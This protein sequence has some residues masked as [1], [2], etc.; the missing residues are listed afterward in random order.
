MT[1]TCRAIH[2]AWN[3]GS[4]VLPPT[5]RAIHAAWNVGIEEVDP[6]HRA[7]HGSW[8][9][10]IGIITLLCRAIHAGWS[11]VG[12]LDEGDPAEWVLMSADILT[13]EKILRG[14]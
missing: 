4:E 14:K 13:I 1:I 11:V 8:N 6:T 10:G 12:M 5:D 7:I 9:V 2:A 3:I